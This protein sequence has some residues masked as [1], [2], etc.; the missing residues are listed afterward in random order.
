MMIATRHQ[1]GRWVAALLAALLFFLGTAPTVSAEGDATP[2]W[3]RKLQQFDRLR[4][5]YE[6]RYAKPGSTHPGTLPARLLE[7]RSDSDPTTTP[8]L[9][10]DLLFSVH[11]TQEQLRSRDA[12][13]LTR[14]GGVLV[15]VLDGGFNLD[16]PE[17]AGRVLPWGFDAVDLDFDPHDLGDGYDDDRDGITDSG[18]GHGTF[19]AG[20]VL[21]AAPDATI[22]PIRVRDDEGWGT[23]KELEYGLRFAWAMGAQIVNVSAMPTTGRK[24][25][26]A[27]LI[28]DMRASG[29]VIV[30]S[31]GNDGVEEVSQLG[32]WNDTITVGSVDR[33]NRVAEFSNA[34]KDPSRIVIYAPGVDLYGPLG[35][36]W[37]H[38]SGYWSGTSFSAGLVSGAAALLRSLHPDKSST[39]LMWRLRHAADPVRG[40]DGRYLWHGSLNLWKAVTR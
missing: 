27:R 16:H 23:D 14:G 37:D 10:G 36:G 33:H 11:T 29:V 32:D 9:D 28:A 5:A 15:A 19:V 12:H 30:N 1:P 22:L 31:A 39:E 18:V 20:M 40:A 24:Q 21:L 4:R 6:A 26:I 8:I 38:S 2:G 35:L 34:S 3:V 17:I 25:R 13:R 7:H